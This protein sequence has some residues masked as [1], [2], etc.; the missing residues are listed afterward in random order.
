MSFSPPALKNTNMW[1]PHAF[2]GLL[3]RRLGHGTRVIFHC[4]REEI[5]AL[6]G[7]GAAYP[8]PET[9]HFAQTAGRGERASASFPAE[10]P[11]ME[12]GVMQLERTEGHGPW[13]SLLPCRY[14]PTCVLEA[15]PEKTPAP[16][17]SYHLFPGSRTSSTPGLLCCS[18][19]DLGN[20][21]QPLVHRCSVHA[22]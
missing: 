9:G 18:F 4:A 19:L 6:K 13:L 3:P 1:A 16:Q 7:S 14:I 8:A 15:C 10:S 22:W 17:T 5:E 20:P 21:A 11:A 12:Y 2:A